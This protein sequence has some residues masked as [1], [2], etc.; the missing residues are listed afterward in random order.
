[1]GK[2]ASQRRA[3]AVAPGD[4]DISTAAI[5]RSKDIDTPPCDIIKDCLSACSGG[6]AVSP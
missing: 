6:L 3:H 2:G 5:G 1:V 4:R